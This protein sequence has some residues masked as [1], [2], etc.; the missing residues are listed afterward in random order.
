[1]PDIAK[2]HGRYGEEVCQVAK[3]CYRFTAPASGL[4]CYTE[5][6]DFRAVDGCELY[7]PNGDRN[8]KVAK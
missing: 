8:P 7:W 6:V 2:C 1:M 4:Q 3:D 5:P